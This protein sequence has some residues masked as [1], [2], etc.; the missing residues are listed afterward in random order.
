MIEIARKRQVLAGRR[1]TSDMTDLK[2]DPKNLQGELTDDQKVVF[3]KIVASS[4]Q[5]AA[6]QYKEGILF[7]RYLKGKQIAQTE[8]MVQG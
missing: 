2:P 3:G 5:Q 1:G 8:R 6:D 4:G 7:Q